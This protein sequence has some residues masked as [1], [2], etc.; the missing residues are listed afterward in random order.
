MPI[1]KMDSSGKTSNS[2]SSSTNMPT[3]PQLFL[4][5]PMGSLILYW[6]GLYPL[7]LQSIGTDHS[8]WSAMTENLKLLL[9]LSEFISS[10]NSSHLPGKLLI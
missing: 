1:S 7:S 9:L 3:P 8:S 2:N 10:E 5:A 4:F 6:S